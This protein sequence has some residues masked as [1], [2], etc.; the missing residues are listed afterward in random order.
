MAKLK[1]WKVIP[2]EESYKLVGKIYEDEQQRF[3]D[4]RQIKTSSLKSID[5]ENKIAQTK[6]S[7]YQ[8][9]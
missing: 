2:E 6:H 3:V 1:E 5:F 4:G 8:L 9:D 7:T